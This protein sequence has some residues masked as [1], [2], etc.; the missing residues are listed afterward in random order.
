[1]RNASFRHPSR[2]FPPGRVLA[3]FLP[4]F[5]VQCSAHLLTR[6][7]YDAARTHHER[8]NP[9]MALETFPEGESG[10]FITVM[11]KTYLSLLSGKADIGKL[12]R[13]A[14]K[15]DDRVRFKVSRDIKGFFYMET[16][17]GYY[18]SE[19]EVIWMHML[20]SW[21]YLLRGEREKA[22]VEARKSANL[23]STAWSDEGQF[24][25]PLLRVIMAG[26]WTMLDRWESARVD[27][28][29][30]AM[31]APRLTWAR[32]LADMEERP[33]ELVIVLGGPGPEPFWSP[34]PAVNPFRGFRGMEFKG[35]GAKSLL[36]IKDEKSRRLEM[37]L[38][39]DSSYWYKRHFIRDNEISDLIKDSNYATRMTASGM[40]ATVGVGTGIAVGA[41]IM[42]GGIGIGGAI[43]YFGA[44]GSGS[45]E[46]F[47]LGLSVA[48]YGTVQGFSTGSKIADSGINAAREDL[49][50]S[51]SYRFVRFLPEYAWVGWSGEP[52]AHPL[53]G[54]A[55]RVEADGFYREGKGVTRINGVTI[56]H[57]PD[58]K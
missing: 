14:K 53:K 22:H 38:T 52:L 4:L 34:R 8:G 41:A 16:P 56:L 45:A 18:A 17:E 21:G 42:A 30:A 19:H 20:L 1:M 39:P 44:M 47:T 24:D 51:D 12:E 48:V 50:M 15:V 32:K 55:G 31:M 11:E 7:D 40:K 46:V 3:L 2:I 35:G 5:L 9:G 6:L 49:D 25:D 28:R 58:R 43:I 36:V 57:Y 13:Y 37:N 27:L 33:R 26:L 10:S 29:R 23:L 54:Y